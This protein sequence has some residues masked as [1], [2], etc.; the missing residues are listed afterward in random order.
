[1]NSFWRY[2]FEGKAKGILFG[3][4]FSR[5]SQ[6]RILFGDTFSRAGQREVLSGGIFLREI[7]G[8]NFFPD[9]FWGVEER[10]YIF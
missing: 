3:D 4:V 6:G 7:Q 2:F 8:G 1:V 10:W 5:R 9:T